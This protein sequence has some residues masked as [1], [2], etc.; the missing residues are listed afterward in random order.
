MILG[1]GLILCRF[2][3]EAHTHS[4]RYS[5]KQSRRHIYIYA[6]ARD[7][8]TH[9]HMQFVLNMGLW[10]SVRITHCKN[11]LSSFPWWKVQENGENLLVLRWKSMGA[12][13]LGWSR[14]LCFVG[15]LWEFCFWVDIV[16]ILLLVYLSSLDSSRLGFLG[17]L[18]NPQVPKFIYLGLFEKAFGH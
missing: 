1:L 6:H 18:N 10:W 4:W 12:T 9:T 5:H 8:Y 16:F 11:Q 14:N 17:Y 15:F 3:F 7:I 13:I 2:G